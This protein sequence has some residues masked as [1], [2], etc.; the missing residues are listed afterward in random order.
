VNGEKM[1]ISLRWSP[2]QPSE[3]ELA[4]IAR[5]SSRPV[6]VLYFS[7]PS[8]SDRIRASFA[9]CGRTE[10]NMAW[11]REQ[12]RDKNLFYPDLDLA[13]AKAESYRRYYTI[14]T[15]LSQEQVDQ[16]ID[17]LFYQFSAPRERNLNAS[18]LSLAV[19]LAVKSM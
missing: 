12:L 2:P 17:Y 16:Y 6:E 7:N 9:Q 4:A 11:L 13:R 19:S 8:K 10:T 15:A 3:A 5:A 18:R 14:N 1:G